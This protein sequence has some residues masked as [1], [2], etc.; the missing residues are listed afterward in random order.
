MLI[1]M[2][3]N[4]QCQKG[5]TLVELLVVIAILGTLAAIAVPKYLDTTT[6]AKGAKIVADL[7]TIDSAI[8]M[9]IA[10]GKTV[11]A[12]T[13]VSATA[14]A[15]SFHE[16]V[17][18]RLSTPG[19]VKPPGGTTFTVNGTTYTKLNPGAYA[20]GAA[21]AV[22]GRAYL[23]TTAASGGTGTAGDKTADSF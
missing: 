10:D 20:I 4:L 3:K 2:R 7:R 15:G 6:T 11:A 9:A 14:T 16:A 1:N 8:M 23:N 17:Q 13:D 5:F 22:N 21:G 18:N 12:V 19:N